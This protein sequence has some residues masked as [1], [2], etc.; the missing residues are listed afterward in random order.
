MSFTHKYTEKCSYFHLTEEALWT[1]EPNRCLWEGGNV[2]CDEKAEKKRVGLFLFP[3][4][5]SAFQRSHQDCLSESFLPLLH[6]FLPSHLIPPS[7]LF[8]F[9]PLHS[10]QLFLNQ[11]PY[12][13]QYVHIFD[14]YLFDLR[15][16]P[17]PFLII[18]IM[19]LNIFL[20]EYPLQ[21]HLILINRISEHC[22]I[23]HY[24]SHYE[25]I[26]LGESSSI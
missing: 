16:F 2:R 12:N 5:C 21:W 4:C 7:L 3:W 25:S 11:S 17:P 9:L 13:I 20:D 14:P 6:L 8:W 10:N 1:L 26:I 19:A 22:F 24:S 15:K 23:L 18:L